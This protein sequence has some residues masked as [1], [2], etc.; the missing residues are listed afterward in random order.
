MIFYIVG[1]NGTGATTYS[2]LNGGNATGCTFD[3]KNLSSSSIGTC[4]VQ[5]VKSGDRNYFADTA[6]AFIYFVDFVI[7][8]P[9]PA[10]GSGPNIALSG[11]T[12]VQ[13]DAN[14]APTISGISASS[15]A[16][17]STLTITGAGFY[18]A[19]PSNLSIKFW[20]NVSAVT[21]TIVNDTTI[22]VTVPAGANTGRIL[23]TTPNGQAASATFTVTS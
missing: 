13:L 22:T 5:V 20:R 8:Q 19:D 7:N 10:V 9:A 2:M 1:G 17:G 3:Y 23:I 14:V 12:S 21:Y 18:F 15:G 6:T 4:Q 11:A 16:V